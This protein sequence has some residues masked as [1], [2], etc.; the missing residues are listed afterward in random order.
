MGNFVSYSQNKLSIKIL[1][2]TMR[3]VVSLIGVILVAIGATF[4]K[5]GLVGL[6]PFTATNIGLAKILHMGLGPVQ[7]GFNI[8]IFLI[9]L[10]LD[11]HQIGIGTFLN[12]ILV[13]FGIQFFSNLY[14]N[15]LINGK[16]NIP[17]IIIDAITGLLIFTLGTSLYMEASLGVAPYDAL[18][19]IIVKKTHLKYQWVRSIQDLAFMIVGYLVH[20]DVGFMTVIVAFFAGP[21]INFWNVHVS[22]KVVNHADS[23]SQNK[24][25]ARRVGIGTVN[26][27]KLAFSLV[28]QAY[29]RTNDMQR[30]MSSYTDN[31]LDNMMHDTKSKM[32]INNLV[33]SNLEN[34]YNN[35]Q[36]EVV[37]RRSKI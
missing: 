33:H 12:M 22:E 17:I 32:H 16:P 7:L 34:R 9:V 30:N 15:F 1:K 25:R 20:G 6:D 24:K 5:E 3:T 18:A 13:G 8:I 23:F 27:G 29:N 35:I 4:L 36:K 2:L 19:P 28:R 31:E 14:Q 37:K 26:I 11:R 21:L 10:L